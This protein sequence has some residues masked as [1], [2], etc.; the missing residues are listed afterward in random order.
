MNESNLNEAPVLTIKD[1][2]IQEIKQ[3][4]KNVLNKYFQGREYEN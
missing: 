4:T 3:K 1:K 2:M